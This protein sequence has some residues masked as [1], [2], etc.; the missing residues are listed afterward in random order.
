[1]TAQHANQ[2]VNEH[3]FTDIDYGYR[4]NWTVYNVFTLPAGYKVEG[5]PKSLSIVMPDKSIT[6][7]RIVNYAD[8]TVTVRYMIDHAKTIYFKEDYDGFREF[9]RQVFDMLNEQIVLKKS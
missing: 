9:N 7:K 1:M 2:F 5:L 8:N 6:F 3:R 4:D